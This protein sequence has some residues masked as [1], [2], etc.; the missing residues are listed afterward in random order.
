MK[1]FLLSLVVGS[2]PESAEKGQ[3]EDMG[4]RPAPQ[5]GEQGAKCD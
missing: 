2:F 4:K 3:V 5:C 1:L